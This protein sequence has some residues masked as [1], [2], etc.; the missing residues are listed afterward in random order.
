MRWEHLLE[1]VGKSLYLRCYIRLKLSLIWSFQERGGKRLILCSWI[2]LL[3]MKTSYFEYVLLWRSDII[4]SSV[5]P[6]TFCLTHNSDVEQ[7]VSNF[8]TT[9]KF[10]LKP[11][12]IKNQMSVWGEECFL[13]YILAFAG[14]RLYLCCVIDCHHLVA[15]VSERTQMELNVSFFVTGPHS[16]ITLAS[17]A[18]KHTAV[19]LLRNVYPHV[20]SHLEPHT[21]SSSDPRSFEEHLQTGPRP[22]QQCF[23]K[24]GIF[25][26]QSASML[27]V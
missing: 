16:E 17:F 21:S 9:Q 6:N 7:E 13:N 3:L 15:S 2:L 1:I 5:S 12:K 27:Y 23:S 26:Q 10:I 4:I 24:A 22:E 20:L 14:H 18:Y 11:V 19:R 25:S 8:S